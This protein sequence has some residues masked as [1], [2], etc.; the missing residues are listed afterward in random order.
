MHNDEVFKQI[1]I[2]RTLQEL[3]VDDIDKLKRNNQMAMFNKLTGVNHQE[4][5]V[6]LNNP[7]SE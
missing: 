5:T 1:Y 6:V 3:C 4:P 7:E 2:P